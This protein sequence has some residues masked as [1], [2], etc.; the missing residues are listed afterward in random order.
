MRHAKSSWDSPA[1]NDHERPLNDR[2]RR[3]SPRVAQHLA[4]IG[5]QPQLILSSD[6]QR[7][8]ETAELMLSVWEAG[9]AVEFSPELYLAGAGA[10]AGAVAEVSEIGN[11]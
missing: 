5:W 6:A 10:V 11:L 2:G 3:D 1:K 7:T 8:R 9:V 4:E